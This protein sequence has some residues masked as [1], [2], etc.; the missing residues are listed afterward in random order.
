[1]PIR[2]S[3]AEHG[4]ACV[5]AHGVELIGEVWT[6][7]LLREMFLGPKRFGELLVLVHGITPAVLTSRL[8]EMERRGLVRSA[9]LA[10]PARGSVY[11]L[12][13]WGHALEPLVEGLSR[14]AHGSTTREI[15]DTG[16]TPDGAVLA[17]K[18]MAG[19]GPAVPVRIAAELRDE[20]TE[21]RE[22]Y[23]YTLEWDGGGVRAVRGALAG[24]VATV[25][26]DS[27]ALAWAVF[28]ADG[29]SMTRGDGLEVS[30]DVALLD[31]LA[32][33]ARD[34]SERAA[35]TAAPAWTPEL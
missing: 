28:G 3:Y 34:G 1:M 16:L 6:Y 22:T 15:E 18:T 20:R 24:T 25:R 9:R 13:D 2:R 19:P 35:A 8:R 14:W 21:R 12:T 5:G 32:A 10:P 17:L 26:G 7:P 31:A 29:G 11:E 33:A 23:T 30:G 4:D 27:T